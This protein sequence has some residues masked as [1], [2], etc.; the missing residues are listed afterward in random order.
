MA[1]IDV[2][3]RN[4][5]FGKTSRKDTWW[6]EPLVIFICYIGFLI[7]ANWR[8]YENAFYEVAGTSYLAPL[9]SP[10]IFRNRPGWW[11]AFLPWSAAALIMWAPAGFRL[12]CYYYRGA[13]YKGIC[14]RHRR[15]GKRAMT[16]Y[17]G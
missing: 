14:C 5:G 8:I 17:P 13:Y 10:L 9:Y 4:G 12:T 7:Y 2:P 15:C 1:S 6:V 11:P 3:L 16:A